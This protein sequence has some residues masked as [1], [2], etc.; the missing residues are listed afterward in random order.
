MRWPDLGHVETL[1]TQRMGDPVAKIVGIDRIIGVL[2]LTA[3]ACREMAARRELMV[4]SR[5]YGSV[6]SDLI[7]GH[8]Q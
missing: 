7:A 2:E 5:H 6:G 1:S 3:S 8:G 4:R